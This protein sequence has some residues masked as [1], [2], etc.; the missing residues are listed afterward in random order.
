[1]SGI[2]PERARTVSGCGLS[3]QERQRS[4]AHPRSGGSESAAAGLRGV[5]PPSGTRATAARLHSFL[6]FLSAERCVSKAA[7]RDLVGLRTLRGDS[8]AAA[9]QETVS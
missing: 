5:T 1:M 8:T 7:Q 6:W 3:E 2:K 9:V 4:L